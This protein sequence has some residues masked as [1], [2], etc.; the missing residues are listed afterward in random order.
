MKRLTGFLDRLGGMLI[1]PRAV[2]SGALASGEGGLADLVALLA[3]QVLAVHLS[4]LAV[5]VLYIFK[6][7]YSA[8]VSMLLTAVADAVWV[9][10]AAVLLASLVAGQLTR[11]R[12]TRARALD[13][14]C[15]A[16]LP[17]IALQLCASLVVALAGI[18]VGPPLA[19]GVLAASGLWFVVLAALVVRSLRAG[20]EP[21]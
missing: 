20:S 17:P 4:R 10:L 6:V 14:C 18:R 19:V 9:P 7:S 11:G 3:V 8:G 5:A 21:R 13:L 12:A 16:A 15:L 2:L 1:T